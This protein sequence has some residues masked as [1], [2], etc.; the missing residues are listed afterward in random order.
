M[1]KETGILHQIKN[2][3]KVGTTHKL[4]YKHPKK[5]V[6]LW[7]KT[8]PLPESSHCNEV[9]FAIRKQ[10]VKY[11]GKKTKK[12]HKYIKKFTGFI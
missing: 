8:I 7:K 2:L 4:R 3:G 1:R 12:L 11:R 5:L 10:L 6:K 9:W